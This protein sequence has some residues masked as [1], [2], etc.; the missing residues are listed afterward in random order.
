[1]ITI[2]LQMIYKNSGSILV[3]FLELWKNKQELNNFLLNGNRI[4]Y[5]TY[6]YLFQT[7]LACLRLHA[8]QTQEFDKI[9]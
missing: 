3:T 2:G 1:M 7:I 6:V 4:P 9:S 8:E 5:V